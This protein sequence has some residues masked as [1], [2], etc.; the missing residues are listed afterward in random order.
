MNVGIISRNSD[1]DKVFIKFEGVN[2]TLEVIDADMSSFCERIKTKN[3]DLLIVTLEL[4]NSNFLDSNNTFSGLELITW[5]RL[6]GIKIH[7][8]AVSFCPLVTILKNSKYARIIGSKGIS[9]LQLPFARD[10][11]YKVNINETSSDEDLKSVLKSI[12]SIESFR[13]SEANW[14]GIKSLW[15]THTLKTNGKFNKPYP[16]LVQKAM[17][18]I[19]S[20]IAEFIYKTDR[21]KISD[22]LEYNRLKWQKLLKDRENRK[23]KKIQESE[24]CEDEINSYNELIEEGKQQII[25]LNSYLENKEIIKALYKAGQYNQRSFGIEQKN[26]IKKIEEQIKI[27]E[28]ERE[29]LVEKRNMLNNSQDSE[30]NL[31]EIYE[32]TQEEYNLPFYNTDIKIKIN[33]DN[34][35][36]K[37]TILLID[38]LAEAGWKEAYNF[39]LG[40]SVV[41]ESVAINLDSNISYTDRKQ[42]LIN[43]IK[44]NYLDKL[45]FRTKLLCV[46]LDLRIFEEDNQTKTIDEYT[47]S[48]ILKELKKRYPYIPIVITTASNKLWTYLELRKLGVDAYWNKEG[49]DNYFSNKESIENYSRLI[50]IVQAFNNKEYEYLIKF[51]HVLQQLNDKNGSSYWWENKKWKFPKKKEVYNQRH[52]KS[53]AIEM[54]T[55]VKREKVIECFSKAVELFSL[56]LR[57][58]YIEDTVDNLDSGIYINSVVIQ[59]GKLIEFF[60]ASHLSDNTRIDISAI[61][62]SR[63]DDQGRIL[64]QTRNK[65]AHDNGSINFKS[66]INNFL[67]YITL[68][69]LIENEETYQ[70]FIELNRRSQ[71]TTLQNLTEINKNNNKLEQELTDS[72]DSS[73]LNQQEIKVIDNLDIAIEESTKSKLDSES[74]GGEMITETVIDNVKSDE[75][76]SIHQRNELEEQVPEIVIEKIEKNEVH[77]NVM[78]RI[79]KWFYNLFSR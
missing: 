33:K 35:L 25:D 60:H 70:E 61:I 2:S 71:Q 13:H 23:E 55:T 64:Y 22:L 49:I 51:G 27:L 78:Q 43:L 26:E 40:E 76:E 56:Y 8:L 63:G 6:K 28:R 12:F 69:D 20:S 24:N 75:T 45:I 74:I 21:F 30:P 1:F 11:F 9:F 29:D 10:D 72:V 73:N 42:K 14:W 67:N 50:K 62:R 41:I 15:D 34:I 52:G 48:I 54:E 58:K 65:A 38:D 44:S 18:N 17:K 16:E 37:N 66:F 59:L 39:V 7:I 31:I 79:I 3:Y 53:L 36:K 77:I 46:F 32:E 57:G 5:L 19:N 4:K 68:K 47:G